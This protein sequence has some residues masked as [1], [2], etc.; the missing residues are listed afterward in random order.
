MFRLQKLFLALTILVVLNFAGV[1]VNATTLVIGNGDSASRYAFGMDPSNASSSFP[2]FAAGG[3]YQQVYGSSAFTGPVTIT[4]IAIASS[5]QI[6]SGPGTATYDFKVSLSSTGV[7]PGRLSTDLAANRGADFV[8]LFSG[9]VTSTIT[10]NNQFDLLIDITPFTYNPDNG[11]LLLEVEMN[12]PTQFTGGPVLYFRAGFDSKT[13]RAANP[14]GVPGGAFTDGFGLLTRFTTLAP[15]AT[16][17]VISGEVTDS[18]GAP[19]PGV[20]MRLSGA[21]SK[22]TVTDE[23][24]RYRFDNIGANDFYTITPQLVNFHFLPRNRSFSLIG[25]KTDAA[26]IGASDTDPFMN[27]IDSNEFFVRQQY[28]DFLNREP[29]Q[30]G[31]AYWSGQLNQCGGDDDC[32]RQRRIDVS[33]AFFQSLEFQQTGSYIYRLYA[34]ALAR[35]LRYAEFAVDSRRVVGGPNL[36]AN[37]ISF[38]REFV[39]RPEFVEKYQANMSA[40]SFVDA[41]LQTQLNTTGVDLSSE[42]DAL[43]TRYNSGRTLNEGRARA[44]FNVAENS[45]FVTAVFNPAFVQMEYFGYLRREIDSGGYAFWLN[46]LNDRDPGNYRGMVCSFITSAEYQR[47]FGEIVTRGNGECGS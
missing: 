3:I 17:P 2:D 37:K 1:A 34:G 24:G 21:A 39:T 8:Q 43:I 40:E 14:G 10:A 28:L 18:H 4:Q 31:L 29:D 13:S 20:T 45:A 22:T 6:T 32:L 41:L 42:R 30:Q 27:A 19:V 23:N 7:A 9:Q 35:K 15:T 11:N 25:T 26:F 5:S 47:R 36:E 38:V 16:S 46:I 33:A 44:V 12:S